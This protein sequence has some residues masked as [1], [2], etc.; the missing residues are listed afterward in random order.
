MRWAPCALTQSSCPPGRTV[1][2]RPIRS[3]QQG[4]A[5]KVSR[6]RAMGENVSIT[7][8]DAACQT[9]LWSAPANSTVFDTPYV[10]VCGCVSVAASMCVH[11]LFF[12]CLCLLVMTKTAE[13]AL[14]LKS[15]QWAT[16][17]RN[18]HTIYISNTLLAVV[19]P[20]MQDTDRKEGHFLE[21]KIYEPNK[22]VK[23]VIME[24]GE[25]CGAPFTD[26][27]AGPL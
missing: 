7:P 23:R 11:V 21:K 1:S 22:E 20:R 6:E 13:L 2:S 15:D 12:V 5:C 17:E 25:L 19:A 26:K 9:D 18:E 10:C 14:A 27:H 24:A 3:E 8:W 4:G 16:W